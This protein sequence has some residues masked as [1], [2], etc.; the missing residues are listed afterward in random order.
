VKCLALLALLLASSSLVAAP[1]PMPKPQRKPERPVVRPS[2]V[3]VPDTFD[4]ADLPAWRVNAQ[5]LAVFKLPVQQQPAQ[6]RNAD[7]PS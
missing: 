4:G 5:P 2:F 1:A 3:Y 7:P 6:P